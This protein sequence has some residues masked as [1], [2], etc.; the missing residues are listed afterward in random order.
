MNYGVGPGLNLSLILRSLNMSTET[1]TARYT[2]NDILGVSRQLRQT[3]EL[4]RHA[5]QADY[6]VALVGES[7]PARN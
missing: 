4:A 3:I 5:A 2:F 1:W 7:G 6:P